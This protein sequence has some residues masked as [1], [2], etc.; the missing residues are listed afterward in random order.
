MDGGSDTA[1]SLVGDDGSEHVSNGVKEESDNL[2]NVLLDDLDSYLKDI[3]DRLVIS[4]MVSDSVIKGMVN[5]VEQE[6]S[7]KIAA[8]EL[9]VANLRELLQNHQ[10]GINEIEF[11]GFQVAYHEPISIEHSS[12]DAVAGDNKMGQTLGSLR[13]AARNEIKKLREEINSL[14]GSSI[15]GICSSSELAELGGILQ[16]K[17]FDTTDTLSTIVED[18]FALANASFCEWQ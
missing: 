12:F 18:M 11:S 7:E 16:E 4:R 14:G 6:A 17:A 5:A 2:G 3:Y 15:R 9:E 10:L 1:T 13:N 8:K